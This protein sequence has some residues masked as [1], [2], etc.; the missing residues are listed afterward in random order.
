MDEG[1][2]AEGK[3]GAAASNNGVFDSFLKKNK[4]R[5]EAKK[6]LGII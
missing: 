1:K 2:C 4:E 6:S 5:S 3:W